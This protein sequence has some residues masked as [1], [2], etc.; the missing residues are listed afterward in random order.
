M[1]IALIT[2][3]RETKAG[4]TAVQAVAGSSSNSKVGTGSQGVWKKHSMH[5][6][7]EVE[8][9]GTCVCVCVDDAIGKGLSSPEAE[10][11]VSENDADELSDPVSVKGR[12]RYH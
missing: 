8:G 11:R 1:L 3:S 9:E 5:V 4:V 2:E 12:L 6:S 10:S 7:A